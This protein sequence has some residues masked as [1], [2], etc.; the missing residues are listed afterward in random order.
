MKKTGHL[1]IFCALLAFVAITVSQS[2]FNKLDTDP[3]PQADPDEV[4]LTWDADDNEDVIGYKI[5]YGSESGNYAE[6]VDVG[7]TENPETPWHLFKDL[8]KGK[9][10]FF[11]VTAYDTSNNES[12]FSNE[13]IKQIPK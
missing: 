4:L 12:G 3:Y 13:V 5:Y 2:C 10:Y 1:K 7:L 9:T 8:D 11:A 6:C